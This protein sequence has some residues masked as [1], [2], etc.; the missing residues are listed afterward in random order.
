M[1][2]LLY[3]GGFGVLWRRG[4]E[5]LALLLESEWNP[6]AYTRAG[7]ESGGPALL[8]SSGVA[9]RSPLLSLGGGVGLRTLVTPSMLMLTDKS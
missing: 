5:V 4:G 2:E 6:H 1:F 8:L 9:F 7:Q 3:M